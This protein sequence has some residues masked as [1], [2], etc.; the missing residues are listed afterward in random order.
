MTWTPT[1]ASGP[2]GRS[3]RVSTSQVHDPSDPEDH[4]VVLLDLRAEVA[5]AVRQGRYP[6][7]SQMN[8]SNGT[9]A[10]PAPGDQAVA[11]TVRQPHS[12]HDERAY[13]FPAEVWLQGRDKLAKIRERPGGQV[14][15]RPP[16]KFGFLPFSGE[17]RAQYSTGTPRHNSFLLWRRKLAREPA[18]SV[19]QGAGGAT[20]F[21]RM[22]ERPSG[23]CTPALVRESAPIWTRCEQMSQKCNLLSS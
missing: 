11:V 23:P 5:Q 20:T 19:K 2:D 10:L 4:L 3:N 22:Q 6:K 8:G 7:S 12:G 17:M 21:S 1:P 9:L 13:F 16:V 18:W 14:L 15:T